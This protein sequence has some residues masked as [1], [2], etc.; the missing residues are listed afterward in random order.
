MRL[1]G[2][3]AKLNVLAVRYKSVS[4][5]WIALAF[6]SKDFFTL[7]ANGVLKFTANLYLNEK[8]R[9]FHVTS[10]VPTVVLRTQ[11]KSDLKT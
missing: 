9:D 1:F 2:V 8:T 5:I 7:Q 3:Q 10:L 11:K 4:L 6:L